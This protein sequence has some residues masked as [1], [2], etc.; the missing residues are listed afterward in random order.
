MTTNGIR[1]G[2]PAPEPLPLF[3]EDKITALW[4]ER[5]PLVSVLCPTYNHADF[6]DDAIRGFLGQQTTFPFEVIIRDDASTDETADIVREYELKYPR[7]I[8]GIYE[9][10]NKYKTEQPRP[11]M[12]SMAKGDFIAYCEGDDYWI[13]PN[14]LERQLATLQSRD[15]CVVSHHQ[16]LVIENDRVTSSAKLPE[17]NERDFSPAELQKGEW[18]LT[19]SLLYRRVD[20]PPHPKAHRFVNG[21]KYL[22]SRLG[23]HGGAA[24]EKDFIGAVYRRH[25]FGVWSS[26]DEVDRRITQATSFYYIAA[27]YLEEGNQE[28]GAHW[29]GKSEMQIRRLFPKN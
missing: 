18:M 10:E 25:G 23:E 19:L 1:V 9:T 13:S 26:L 20:I 6:I 16:A 22:T 5:K 14:K 24:Y 3:S 2:D 11:R 15:D 28:L 17:K 8:R 7:I 29:L 4:K 27:Q 12:L 21:D